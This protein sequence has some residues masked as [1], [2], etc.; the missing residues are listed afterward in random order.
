ME[1]NRYKRETKELSL[2]EII[3]QYTR[4]WYL[5]VLGV[6]IALA[7]AFVYLRY[8]TAL[9][10]TRATII[11]KDEKSASSPMEMAAFSQFGSFLS[12]FNTSKIDNELAIFNSKRIISKTI[13]ELG[14]NVKYE[15]VG[16]IKTSEI[17]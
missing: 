1:E 6:I 12:R 8:T 17:Y 10:Q 7:L 4:Y 11:I 15:S 13:K 3:E 9:Y 2:R 16:A 5:F 14:L